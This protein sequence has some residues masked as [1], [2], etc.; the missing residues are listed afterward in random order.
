MTI[1][2]SLI[3]RLNNQ[4]VVSRD[5]ILGICKVAVDENINCFFNLATGVGKGK[6]V[7]EICKGKTL[8]SHNQTV[9]IENFIRDSKKHKI[10]ISN[11]THTIWN[12]YHK[13][14]DEEW[15]YIVVDKSLSIFL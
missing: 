6:I 8:M 1:S 9:H 14:I 13:H 3:K 12:S 7:M 11:F 4:E 5:D 15:D 10:D 2:E